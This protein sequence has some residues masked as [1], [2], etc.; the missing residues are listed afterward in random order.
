MSHDDP[1]SFE[2]LIYRVWMAFGVPAACA[3]DKVEDG[4]RATLHR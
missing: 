1:R 4:K 2:T 3:R